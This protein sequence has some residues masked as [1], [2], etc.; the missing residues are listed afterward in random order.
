MKVH[1]YQIEVIWLVLAVLGSWAYAAKL[2]VL[3]HQLIK[4]ERLQNKIPFANQIRPP[5]LF[6]WCFQ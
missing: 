6:G 4:Q 2:G 3:A 1:R 5:P